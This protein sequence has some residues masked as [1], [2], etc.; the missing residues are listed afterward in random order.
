[1]AQI[2]HDPYGGLLLASKRGGDESAYNAVVTEAALDDPVPDDAFR[3]DRELVGFEQPIFDD[4]IT[5]VDDRGGRWSRN[6]GDAD[7]RQAEPATGRASDPLSSPLEVIPRPGTGIAEIH[8]DD[9]LVRVAA[10]DDGPVVAAAGSPDGRRTAVASANSVSIIDVDTGIRRVRLVG[11]PHTLTDVAWSGDGRSVWATSG[12]TA[13]G[14]TVADAKVILDEPDAW[15]QAILPAD[16]EGEA[17]LVLRDGELRRV[18]LETGKTLDQIN[19]HDELYVVSVDP[20]GGHVLIGGEDDDHLVDL[21]TGRSKDLHLAD[22][23]I[24]RGAWMPDGSGAVVP[25]SGGPI[26]FVDGRSGKELTRVDIPGG[27]ASTVSVAPTLDLFVG[28]STGEVFHFG[29]SAVEPEE[30]EV[31]SCR[32]SVNALAVSTDASVAIPVGDGE[33]QLGCFRRGIRKDGKWTWDAKLSA[34]DAGTSSVAAAVLGNKGGTFAIGF[35]DGTIQ[36]RP[37]EN[38]LPK[39]RITSLS[40]A[41]RSFLPGRDGELYV[42]TRNGQLASIPAADSVPSNA[43]FAEEAAKRL[44]RAK[45]LGFTP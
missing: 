36:L 2:R 35:S 7:V 17:W 25:C 8:R 14:W 33:G 39:R 44:Q 9:H 23:E 3:T 45:E 32:S 15:F 4:E 22:C 29:P 13:I 12:A 24:G 18:A 19:L 34:N 31:A 21:R 1:V 38:I 16:Y 28:G 41:A 6:T 10:T 30:L 26:V 40:G 20:T 42:V 37:T 43:A 27:G 5:V 11:S